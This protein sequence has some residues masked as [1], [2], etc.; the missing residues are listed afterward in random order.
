LLVWVLRMMLYVFILGFI[1]Q[2]LWAQ[3]DLCD[4]I[5]L[6]TCYEVTRQL[7]RSSAASLPSPASSANLNPANVSFDRGVGIEAVIQSGNPVSYNLA[8]GN[9]KLGGALISQSLENSFFGNRVIELDDELL[10]R[11]LDRRQYK[12]NK[13]SLALAG[14]L[15]RRRDFALDAGIL[16]KRHS[17]IKRVNPGLGISGRIG[18]IHLGASIYQDDLY[19]D[20]VGHNDPLTGIPYV[21]LFNDESYTERFIVQA[22]SVGTRIRNLALDAGIIS[23][24]YDLYQEKSII[25]LYSASLSVNKFIYNLGY[26]NEVTPGLKVINGELVAMSDSHATFAGIQRSFGRHIIVGLNYNFYLLRE[27]SVNTTFYF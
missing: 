4:I 16:L 19:L 2:S 27:F 23:T 6:D 8:S 11:H 9:G 13:F 15:F 18:P 20:L 22:F 24:E 10:D 1:S 17:E 12:S 7:R 14:K 21:Q 25:K 5:E 26:R 3:S